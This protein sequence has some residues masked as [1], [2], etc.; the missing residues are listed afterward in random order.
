MTSSITGL[1]KS[2]LKILT[3]HWVPDY[4]YVHIGKLCNCVIH[5]PWDPYRVNVGVPTNF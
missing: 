5:G 2:R 3:G 4:I 1:G